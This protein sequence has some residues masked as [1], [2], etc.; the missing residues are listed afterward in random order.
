MDEGGPVTA[1][2][3]RGAAL[4][5]PFKVPAHPLPQT[6]ATEISVGFEK[7]TQC[8]RFGSRR[9]ASRSCK[10]DAL[11][12]LGEACWPPRRLRLWGVSCIIAPRPSRS[13]FSPPLPTTTTTHACKAPTP[14]PPSPRRV[15][16]Q[17]FLC[18]TF[19]LGLTHAV[20]V[21]K[22]GYNSST[23]TELRVCSSLPGQ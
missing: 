15:W 21:K 1:E 20:L 12:L 22:F 4:R 11:R 8:V 13:S 10:A 2:P 6:R 19:C 14:P 18:P 3:F 5:Q 9:A 7:P 16:N 17:Y 23:R